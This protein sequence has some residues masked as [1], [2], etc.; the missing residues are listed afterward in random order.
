VNRF[1][2]LVGCRLPIQQAGMTRF[3][4]PA[5]AAAVAEAGGLGRHRDRGRRYSS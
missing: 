4:T 1:C 5:L 2:A 3:T